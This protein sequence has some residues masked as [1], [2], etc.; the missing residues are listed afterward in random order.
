M[1]S[2]LNGYGV[3][4]GLWLCSNFGF[5]LQLHCLELHHHELRRFEHAAVALTCIAVVGWLQMFGK[6]IIVES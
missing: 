4:P 5:T 1:R 6:A 2:S 3:M